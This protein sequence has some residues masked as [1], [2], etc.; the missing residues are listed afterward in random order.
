MSR[1]ATFH[2]VED[3][4]EC[5]MCNQRGTVLVFE[6]LSGDFLCLCRKCLIEIL[7][8]TKKIKMSNLPKFEEK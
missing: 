8:K 7:N 5:D 4:R 3:N 6:T 1:Q 2:F